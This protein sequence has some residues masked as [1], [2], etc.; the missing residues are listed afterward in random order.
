MYTVKHK[1]AEGKFLTYGNVKKNKWGNLS[2]GMK[3]TPLLKKLI[4]E[5]PEGE[6]VNF[7]LFAEEAK[8][9]ADDDFPE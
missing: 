6:W 2:L 5:T 1:G 3:A 7:S 4:A 8:Q 9:V